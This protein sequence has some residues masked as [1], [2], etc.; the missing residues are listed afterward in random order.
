[1]TIANPIARFLED[2][3]EE[4]SGT[5]I[6]AFST[7]AG[8][9]DGSS[10]DRITELSPDSTILENYTVQDEEAMDSQDDVEAW[11]EQLGLMGEE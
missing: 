7:N 11:L 9:G 6:A 3:S 1:M 8:Y 10:V 2:N 4:L 5:S